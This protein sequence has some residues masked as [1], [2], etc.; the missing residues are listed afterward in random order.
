[1]QAFVSHLFD[2]QSTNGFHSI[3][4]NLDEGTDIFVL[5]NFNI[6]LLFSFWTFFWLILDSSWATTVLHHTE[7]SLL[8]SSVSLSH[9]SLDASALWSVGSSEKSSSV[10]EEGCRLSRWK[11][12]FTDILKFS[13]KS[14][15]LAVRNNIRGVVEGQLY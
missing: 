8:R 6:F 12:R 10:L 7:E 15:H 1:M 13:S 14:F 5:Y 4:R 9:S 11:W 2:Y 3:K